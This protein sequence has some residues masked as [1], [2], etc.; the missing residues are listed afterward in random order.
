MIQ[1]N[2]CEIN[3][4]FA[5]VT[6][7]IVFVLSFILFR[8]LSNRKDSI[9]KQE[10]IERMKQAEEYFNKHLSEISEFFN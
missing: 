10:K 5:K 1:H 3:E 2:I 9:T 8:Y 7:I 6:T 4:N